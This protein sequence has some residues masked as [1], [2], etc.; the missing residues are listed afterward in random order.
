VHHLKKSENIS[1]FSVIS[2][3]QEEK[4]GKARQ[5]KTYSAFVY[6]YF[7]VISFLGNS[8]ER[9]ITTTIFGVAYK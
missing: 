3:A 6:V 5:K 2:R 1:K 8:L 7:Y 9:K 4:K